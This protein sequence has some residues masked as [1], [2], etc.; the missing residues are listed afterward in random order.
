MKYKKFILFIILLFIIDITLIL[1]LQY[2]S[3]NEQKHA[4]EEYINEKQIESEDNKSIET[5]TEEI[6]KTRFQ[7][8][9]SMD[10]DVVDEF[11][12][13]KIAT[14]KGGTKETKA[15]NIV[16]TLNRVFNKEYPNTITDV[17]LSELYDY[18]G[19]SEYDYESIVP[20]D[21]S[22]DAMMMVYRGWDETNGSL[23]YKK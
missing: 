23:E 20:D 8:K 14:Y 5:N 16:V 15:Y 18:H 17:V 19:I 7:D 3:I 1:A 21:D 12:L 9:Y 11:N 22:K 10:W 4:V 2:Y 6:Q 13:L